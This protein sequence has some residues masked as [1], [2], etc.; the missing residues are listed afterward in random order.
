MRARRLLT[1]TAFVLLACFGLA[2]LTYRDPRLAPSQSVT[3]S[4]GGTQ[5]SMQATSATPLISSPLPPS[6]VPQ[7]GVSVHPTAPPNRGGVN[8]PIEMG[9]TGITKHG[10]ERYAVTVLEVIRGEAALNIVLKGDKNN[11]QPPSGYEYALAK[12]EFEYQQGDSKRVITALGFKSYWNGT[13][14]DPPLIVNGVS[15]LFIFQG[16]PNGRMIGWVPVFVSKSDPSGM[17]AYDADLKDGRGTYF[18]LKKAA[19]N[20]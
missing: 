11:Q 7:N 19:A 8:A 4:T 17:I 12:I 15:D 18:Y 10:N 6:V 9:T 2:L 1:F 13:L 16:E 20:P 14:I 3:A 5:G